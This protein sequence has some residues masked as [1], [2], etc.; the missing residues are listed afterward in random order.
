ML[1]VFD[2]IGV[3]VQR[4]A[5]MAF[6]LLVIVHDALPEA[7]NNTREATTTATFSFL[8]TDDG[9]YGGNSGTSFSFSAHDSTGHTTQ[10]N[11]TTN[12]AATASAPPETNDSHNRQ[13]SSAGEGEKSVSSPGHVSRFNE[14]NRH[15]GKLKTSVDG[16][17][18]EA[19]VLGQLKGGIAQKEAIMVTLL[20][21]RLGNVCLLHFIDVSTPSYENF[22][23]AMPSQQ[24]TQSTPRVHVFP[25]VFFSQKEAAVKAEAGHG[26]ATAGIAA[27]MGT[28]PF[29]LAGAEL[30]PASLHH[31]VKMCLQL[32]ITES[33]S[34]SGLTRNFANDP[35]YQMLLGG[36]SG[37]GEGGIRD[38]SEDP[39][40]FVHVVGRMSAEAR[41][42]TDTE[43]AARE[44]LMTRPA[45]AAP[46]PASAT[47]ASAQPA[48]A[49][50]VP[51]SGT[52]N[53]APR[54]PSGMH[55]VQIDNLP[56][57]GSKRKT[58]LTSANMTARTVWVEVEKAIEK[59]Q[60]DVAEAKAASDWDGV[61][62]EIAK[63]TFYLEI[64][65]ATPHGQNEEASDGGAASQTRSIHSAAEA[66]TV[67][68]QQYPSGTKI[69]VFRVG[70]AKS[71]PEP[72]ESKPAAA[73][74]HE[75]EPSK[76]D[77]EELVV[78][79]DGDTCRRVPKREAEEI[80]KKKKHAEQ[81]ATKVEAPPAAPPS[82]ITIRCSLP[83]GRTEAVSAIDPQHDT[84][85]SRLRP[86]IAALLNT[87]DFAFVCPFPPPAK[88]FT[89]DDESNPLVDVGVRA[90]CALR[91]VLTG[92][93]GGAK[94][95]AAPAA[96][97]ASP[98]FQ[99]DPSQAAASSG[100]MAQVMR[101]MRGASAGSAGPAAPPAASR[102]GI[103]PRPQSAS[104]AVGGGGGGFRTMAEMRAAEEGDDREEARQELMREQMQKM[105]A[106]AGQRQGHGNRGESS[107]TDPHGAHPSSAAAP[108]GAEG[109]DS[110]RSQIRAM[111]D[112]FR[113]FQQQ[114]QQQQR[115]GGAKKSNRYFGGDSTEF[116][117]APAEGDGE[118][119][120]DDG[121]GEEQ[122]QQ[123]RVQAF[124]GVGRRLADG[125][126]IDH[127]PTTTDAEGGRQGAP[128]ASQQ[129]E[130]TQQQQPAGGN[131]ETDAVSKKNQ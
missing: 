20:N 46:A 99:V 12:P 84:L 58:I 81:P 2:N 51:A 98:A 78:V 123:Q 124:G 42:Q 114:Q 22:V 77:D 119:D 104:S 33:L 109:D 71:L 73:A 80:E 38:N 68:L 40:T 108:G 86:P 52:P 64:D 1:R 89:A 28:Y 48:K 128:Q 69:H 35:R 93:S 70:A 56:P 63:D 65:P 116:M 103:N 117:S 115:K 130:Q 10:N 18:N 59:A 92:G 125:Q 50:A 60:A 57:R 5:A 13:T 29:V 41:R 36:G 101:M 126:A 75:S 61:D 19:F 17:L 49:A 45:A 76:G 39:N 11:S 27:S 83:D 118:D 112:F 53:A 97:T 7:V 90:S 96:K 95:S 62:C 25:P 122:P 14:E 43:R 79:C 34:I 113:R 6:P 107:N 3:A 87:Q 106:A 111:E 47:A 129:S 24:T 23:T 55:L 8:P 82:S 100:I 120:D 16:P 127:P 15:L 85:R 26:A 102:P 44:S 66:A 88:R 54:P 74:A 9:A 4:S 21:L 72:P 121:K 94:P 32:P 110:Q 67:Q 37:G 131:E 105:M 91:V 31:A 30:T